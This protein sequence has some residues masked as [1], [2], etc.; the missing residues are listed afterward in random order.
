MH[1]D[2]L[3]WRSMSGDEKAARYTPA[4]LPAIGKR[5]L[6]DKEKEKDRMLIRGI[7]KILAKAGYTIVKVG[8]QR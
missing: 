5:T 3:L 1:K 4:E 8:N 7:P 2:I 6:P